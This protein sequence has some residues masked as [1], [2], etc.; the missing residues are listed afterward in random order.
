MIILSIVILFWLIFGY[1]CFRGACLRKKSRISERRE[2]CGGGELPD[3]AK[4]AV[5]ES[6]RWIDD[7]CYEPLYINSKDGY[8]LFGRLI[9]QK[10]TPPKGTVIFAHGYHSSCRRDLAIQIKTAYDSGYNVLLI[11]QRSHGLSGGKYICFGA[12]E[13]YD[14]L[15]WS[16]YISER[17]PK[18]PIALFGL[19][20]GAATVMMASE[21]PLPENVRCIIADCGFTSPREIIANTLKTRRHIIVYPTIFFM[22]FWSILFARFNYWEVSTLNTLKRNTRPLLLIHG[23]LDTYVPTEMS[24]RNREEGAEIKELYIVPEAK[25]AQAVYFDTEAYC[26]KEIEFLNEYM[27]SK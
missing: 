4:T 23:G 8:R 3:S 26:Q 6:R 7:S 18:L 5:R 16:E 25:H 14:I 2:F 9:V 1:I 22:N 12:K 11:V 17:F 27:K 21:L 10:E 19:S 24:H 13:R 20:M 15:L